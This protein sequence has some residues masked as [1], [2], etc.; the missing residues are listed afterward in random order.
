MERPEDVGEAEVRRAEEEQDRGV[1]EG[2]SDGDVGGPLVERE[3]VDGPVGP[4]ACGAVAQADEGA[5]DEVDGDG[6][7]GEE[8][9]VGAEVEECQAEHRLLSPG[10]K[11]LFFWCERGRRGEARLECSVLLACGCRRGEQ[12]LFYN[13]LLPEEGG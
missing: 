8:A 3:E 10:L 5:E 11:P 4:E 2:G 12:C 1:G 7:D 9:E 13:K 6:A